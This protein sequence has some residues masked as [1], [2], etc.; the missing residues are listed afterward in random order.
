MFAGSEKLTTGVST[1]MTGRMRI[2]A[3]VKAMFLI[4]F[5]RLDYLQRFIK[6][7][8]KIAT[9]EPEEFVAVTSTLI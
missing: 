7:P 3:G 2:D 1:G 8:A 5:L 4:L 6:G 9:V